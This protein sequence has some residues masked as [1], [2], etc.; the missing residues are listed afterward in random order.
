M[1]S[2]VTVAFTPTPDLPPMGWAPHLY[3]AHPDDLSK[4]VA[5]HGVFPEGEAFTTAT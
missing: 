1:K 5:E 3:N 4:A 2:T